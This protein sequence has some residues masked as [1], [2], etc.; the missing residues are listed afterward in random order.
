MNPSSDS[1]PGSTGPPDRQTLQLLERHLSTDPF[2]ADTDSEPD[3]YEP[4]LLRVLL[5]TDLSPES[6]VDARLD[7]RWF[8]TEDFS[9]HYV[10]R[11]VEDQFECRWERHPNDH[12]ARVHFHHPPNCEKVTDLSLP[13]LHPLDLYSTVHDALEQRLETQWES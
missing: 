8:E 13:S 12:N 7:I 3:V 6:V 5:D 4:R 9:I 1:P 10:E 11:T 2:V